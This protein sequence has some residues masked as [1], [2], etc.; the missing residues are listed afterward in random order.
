MSA[1]SNFQQ[2][3]EFNTSF[4]VPVNTTLQ[5][6]LF[7]KDPKLVEYRMSLIREEMKELEE[8]VTTK[9][10]KETVDALTDILYVVYGF[11]TALGVDADKAYDI[12]HRSNMSKLCSTEEEAIKTVEWYKANESRYD[13]PAYRPSADG[14][15]FVV[16]NQS[17]QKVLKN[18]NYTPANFDSLLKSTQQSN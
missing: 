15:Y 2:V 5:N 14:K 16:Y 11:Y 8:A 18:V 1:K 6:E 13:S 10:Y 4:G 3:V 7:D 17:T 12:V 9:D